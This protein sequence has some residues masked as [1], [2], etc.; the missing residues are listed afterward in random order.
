VPDRKR[1]TRAA[2]AQ[3]L[4]DAVTTVG[5]RVRRGS[6]VSAR[7]LSRSVDRGASKM[8]LA[9]STR[10]ELLRLIR[11]LFR[12]DESLRR[13]D[14]VRKHP[15]MVSAGERYFGDWRD[16]V[17]AAGFRVRGYE[18]WS[19]RRVLAEIR[20]RHRR[21]APLAYSRA[22]SQLTDAA[23]THFGAWRNAI[24]LA[25]LDYES[26][27]LR[28]R[29]S[30]EEIIVLLRE[31]ARA[32]RSGVGDGKL[33]SHSVAGHARRK[34]GSL[35]AAC[36]AAGISPALLAPRPRGVPKRYTTDASIAAEVRRLAK[37]QPRMTLAKFRPLAICKAVVKRYGSVEAGAA[38]L[39][40]SGWPIRRAFPLPSVEEIVNG[41]R[42][43]HGRGEPMTVALVLSTER[44]LAKAA[45]LRLGSW[46]AAMR[47][48]G[49]GAEA[50]DGSWGLAQIRAELNGRRLRGEALDKR[51]IL[52]DDPRL[53]SAIIERCGSLAAAIREADLV[54][55]PAASTR[56]TRSA[57]G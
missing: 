16:A 5:R 9:P 10:A 43:R 26:I 34:F 35:E 37:R 13:E 42:E 51:A 2:G 19:K 54:Y 53:W 25:G 45:Y 21:G 31:G 12:R 4:A 7:P 11:V 17:A 20:E 57:R 22:P 28:S 41:V 30:K 32:G 38:A 47:A 3:A 46:R 56:R 39:G 18:R 36:E 44:R 48:A 55:R 6:M 40:V 29:K 49:L 1:R 8:A 24:S 52:R 14:V 50:D 27:S 33:V 23:I 15:R